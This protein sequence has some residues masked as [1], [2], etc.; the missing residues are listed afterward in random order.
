MPKNVR[1]FPRICHYSPADDDTSFG[2]KTDTTPSEGHAR[3]ARESGE[4]PPGA[5]SHG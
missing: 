2:S 4:C 5:I 3:F 1:R